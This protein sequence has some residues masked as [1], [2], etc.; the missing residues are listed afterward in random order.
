[1]S[2]FTETAPVVTELPDTVATDVTRLPVVAGLDLALEKTGVAHPDGTTSRITTLASQTY[3]ERLTHIRRTIKT[4]RGA[5]LLVIED[6]P[7]NVRFGGVDLGMVHGVVRTAIYEWG[8][9]ALFVPPGSL[10]SYAAGKGNASKTDIGHELIK[11]FDVDIRDDNEADAFV[12]RAI[13]L[14]LLGHPLVKMPAAHRAP[15]AKLVM[16][17]LRGA[18]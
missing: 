8:T 18:A 14:D 12:L 1:V 11:R 10:K 5:D 7:K 9:P 3:G 4:F 13:G 17:A 6:L 16:P 2:L 15:L